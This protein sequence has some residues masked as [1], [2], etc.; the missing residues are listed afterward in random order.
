MKKRK[1]GKSGLEVA[2]LAFGGNVFGWTTDE[3]TSF[4]L[5]DAFVDAGFDLIDTA[6]VYSTWVPGH[7]GGESETIIGKWLKSRGR[8]EQVVIAT[9]TGSDMRDFGKGLS[10]AHI[11][12]SVEA[13]LARLQTDYIDLYQSH[14]DDAETPFEETLAAY[15]KLIEQGKVRAIGASNHTRPAP[16]RSPEGERR[17]ASAALSRACSPSTI[18]TTARVSK[19]NSSR[20]ASRR[21]SASFPITRWPPVSSPANTAARRIWARA[22]GAGASAANI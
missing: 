10:K 4:A 16:G 15:A 17:E 21:I 5:L 12:K 18:S 20:S 8:R 2:P 14:I 1:L 11:F 22:P 13:S 19:P 9:K 6:D 7:K 3:A